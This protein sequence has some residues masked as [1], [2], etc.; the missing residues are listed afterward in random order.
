MV[1]NPRCLIS[2]IAVTFDEADRA[3]VRG[4][5]GPVRGGVCECVFIFVFI[6]LFIYL[7]LLMC[8]AQIQLYQAPTPL[9]NKSFFEY[10]LCCLQQF[11]ASRHHPLS[12]GTASVHLTVPPLLSAL[13]THDRVHHPPTF[14]S[15]IV[16]VVA[17]C[18]RRHTHTY[19]WGTWEEGCVCACTC[20]LERV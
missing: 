18:T 20:V 13:R 4:E 11:S 15:W 3:G 10:E 2:Q 8:T 5:A 9:P 17:C 12:T 16:H 7:F 6:Y 19:I 1:S 14:Y